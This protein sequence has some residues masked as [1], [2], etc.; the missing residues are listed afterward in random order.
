MEGRVRWEDSIGYKREGGSTTGVVIDLMER[1]EAADCH[2]TGVT[3]DGKS[4]ENVISV[5]LRAPRAHSV[6]WSEVIA[7]IVSRLPQGRGL[8]APQMETHLAVRPFR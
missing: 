4:Q 5:I 2:D 3:I 8:P 6:F 1:N 7:E